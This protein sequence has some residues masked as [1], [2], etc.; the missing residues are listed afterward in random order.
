MKRFN[1]AGFT[2]IE[3]MLFL[4]VSG[5][6]IVGIL[7]GAG[8]SINSQRY[9]E[10]VRSLQA[11]LQRQFS[12]A[13]NVV[14][15]AGS[16]PCI[17]AGVSTSNPRG[18]S[19]CVILGRYITTADGGRSFL[20]KSVTGEEF[21]SSVSTNDVAALSN[22]NLRTSTAIGDSYSVEWGSTL[23][24]PGTN[25]DLNFSMLILRSPISGVIRTF[26]DP[27]NSIH[28]N[29]IKNLIKSEALKQSVKLCLKSDIISSGGGRSAV[30]INANASSSSAIETLGEV[31]SGC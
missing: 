10:S 4:G 1:Y 27:T 11:M 20:I 6:L 18:Q 7:V 3:T 8:S 23:V 13:S 24:K 29:D 22:Y 12:E 21:S 25:D 30:L 2:I 16:K 26:I 19:E 31:T 5:V 15:E 14:S 17:I 28:E 9:K